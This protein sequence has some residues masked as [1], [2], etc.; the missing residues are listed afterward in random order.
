MMPITI[1]ALE[2]GLFSVACDATAARAFG[3]RKK[4]LASGVVVK[5]ASGKLDFV[6]DGTP[7]AF[8]RESALSIA[9]TIGRYKYGFG[10]LVFAYTSAPEGFFA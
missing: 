9:H 8:D 7:H 4:T 10:D 5:L 2:S 1:T 3:A 6:A